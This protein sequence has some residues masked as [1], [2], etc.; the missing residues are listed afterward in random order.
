MGC[1]PKIIR[2]SM[3]CKIYSFPINTH[4]FDDAGNDADYA[5]NIYIPYGW[6]KIDMMG[7]DKPMRYKKAFLL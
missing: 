1:R 3:L 2:S 4:E 6:I 7:K 5:K